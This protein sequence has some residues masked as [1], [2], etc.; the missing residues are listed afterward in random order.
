MGVWVAF[1]LL[2]IRPEGD[3]HLNILSKSKS[4]D[5]LTY[6]PDLP[7][8]PKHQYVFEESLSFQRQR[9]GV[10]QIRQKVLEL[11]GQ[12]QSQAFEAELHFRWFQI[13]Q[14][15]EH[16]NGKVDGDWDSFCS[17]H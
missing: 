12:Y 5:Y 3:D 11:K 4:L 9:I 1:F 2:T 7:T 14:S 17:L 8:V 6:P 15:V 10:F 13:S 16:A